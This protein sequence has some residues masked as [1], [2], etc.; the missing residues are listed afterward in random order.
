MFLDIAQSRS[1]II[2]NDANLPVYFAPHG[3][4]PGGDRVMKIGGFSMVPNVIKH[5][6]RHLD[7]THN[8]GFTRGSFFA[9]SCKLAIQYYSTSMLQ[10]ITDAAQLQIDCTVV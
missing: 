10:L 3:T 5:T 8:S 4:T 2:R 7:R 6:K 9:F 1:A